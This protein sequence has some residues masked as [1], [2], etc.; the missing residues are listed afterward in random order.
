MLVC[1][2]SAR[3]CFGAA[4]S[5]ASLTRLPNV[6]FLTLDQSEIEKWR[7]EIVENSSENRVLVI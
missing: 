1:Y 5:V 7:Q 4:I 2:Y 6:G 3:I